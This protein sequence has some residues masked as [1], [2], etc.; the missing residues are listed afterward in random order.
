MLLQYTFTEQH[1][2]IKH[3]GY[4]LMFF[5]AENHY[6]V[7]DRCICRKWWEYDLSL[8]F[9]FFRGFKTLVHDFFEYVW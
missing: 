7:D 8:P 5:F 3:G 2:F 4:Y 1:T 9:T 6:M